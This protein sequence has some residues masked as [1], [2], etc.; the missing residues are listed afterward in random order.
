LARLIHRLARIEGLARLRYTTSHPHD[1]SDDLI[2]AHRDE[3]KLMPY[4]HL[5]FQAGS[6]R[7]LAAMNRKHTRADY[8]ALVER[9][10][11][12]R[13]DIALSTDIIVGFPGETEEDFRETLDLV[14][15][16]R[17]AQAYFFKYSPR[18]G[19]PAATLSDQVPEAVKIERLYRLQN[20][21]KQHQTTFNKK[22]VGKVLPVLFDRR[23]RH[24]GQ[25]AGRTPYLQAVHA[26]GDFSA[27]GRV[28]DVEISSAG[29]N[30]LTGTLRPSAAA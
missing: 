20:A 15:R 18:P 29:P 2:A 17:F 3:P 5:P 23:G 30:S 14:D 6:D 24:P 28:L 27:I 21:L 9:I 26:Q 8:A 19:T 10:R 22:M 12:A 4:L 16:V 13:P 7:L 11:A 25:L 1:M